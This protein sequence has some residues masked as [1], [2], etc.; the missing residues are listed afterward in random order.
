MSIAEEKSALARIILNLKQLG[1][2][3]SKLDDGGD[4]LIDV[5]ALG[6]SEVVEECAAVEL[7]H[8]QFVK[9]D[10]LGARRRGTVMII[11]GNGHEDLIADATMKHGFNDA[12][13]TAQRAE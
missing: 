3:A 13:D 12:L 7:C 1:W 8:L 4:E 2:S 5:S 6:V 10:E 9:E 11:W